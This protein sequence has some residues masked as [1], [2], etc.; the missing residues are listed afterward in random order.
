[1]VD[2]FWEGVPN[3][4]VAVTGVLTLA[5]ALTAAIY[6]GRAAHWTKAQA[7]SSGAQA[8]V[9]ADTLR[10]ALKESAAAQER[11]A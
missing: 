4:L 10:L 2:V 9:A 7:E 6:A 3:W 8:A 1:M 11:L 5:A